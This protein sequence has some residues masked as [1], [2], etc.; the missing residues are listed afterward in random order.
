[1]DGL[2]VLIGNLRGDVSETVL[3]DQLIQLLLRRLVQVYQSFTSKASF[4]SQTTQ[5][6]Y[7]NNNK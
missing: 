3:K 6:L 2:A 4:T 7:N 5:L 1:M